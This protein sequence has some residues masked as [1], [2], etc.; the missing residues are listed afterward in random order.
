MEGTTGTV[1]PSSLLA[2]RAA[3]D[4]SRLGK[5]ASWRVQGGWVR[6]LRSRG[7]SH[8]PQRR[9]CRSLGGWERVGKGKAAVP[10]YMLAEPP[11]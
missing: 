3:W 9:L 6:R 7:Q 8:H 11:R 4:V 2:Q 10:V 1:G 5:D